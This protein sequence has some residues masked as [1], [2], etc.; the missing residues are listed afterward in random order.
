MAYSAAKSSKQGLTVQ[1][2]VQN[3]LQMVQP[4]TMKI[5]SLGI[6]TE[7]KDMDSKITLQDQALYL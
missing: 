6:A 3:P 4:S 2:A 7:P 1:A 5:I